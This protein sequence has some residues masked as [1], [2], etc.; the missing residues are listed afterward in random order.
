VSLGFDLSTVQFGEPL[1]LR[2]LL[3][4]GALLFV[5]I[6][7]AGRRRRDRLHLRRSREVPLRERFGLFG[8][9]LFWLCLILALS[10]T[11]LALARPKATV[12]LVRTAGVDLVVLQDGSASMHV[13]DVKP[14]RWQRS[15]RFLRVVAES[16]QWT[17]DRIALALFAHIAA[18]QIRLTR[19]PNTFFFFLDH[20]AQDS[21]F[22]LQDDETWDTNIELG[23]HWGVRLIDKDEE[24]HG[25]SPNARA[26]L[27]VS[28]GQSW[29]GEI[30]R[31]LKLAHSRDIPVFVVGV[32]TTSGGLIPEP[33]ESPTS[34][35]Q[36]SAPAVRVFSTL[37]RASL[38][39][40]ASAGGGRYF[41]LDRESDRTIASTII[42]AA[43][44]H[45]GPRSLEPSFQEL[46]WECLFAAACF[47]GLGVLCLR[48]RGEL[49]IQVL[50]TG[51]ALFAFWTAV[52]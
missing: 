41:D 48:D 31:A 23:I 11:I 20:L 15:T 17:N 21:P 43:R 46:Y 8:G 6:W 34:L 12:A 30:D 33:S 7:Q 52:R 19:D 51:L 27:L 16:L 42:D 37:D 14:D 4:P 39:R 40:I 36:R 29:S 1:Y 24:L 5:W 28:D 44:Q 9:L 47:M 18:P 10:F 25:R 45:A 35:R 3:L 32:G 49:W 50:G 2:L 26:F 22:P 38:L 13:T